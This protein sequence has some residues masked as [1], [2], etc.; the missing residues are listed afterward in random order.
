M[1]E[2]ALDA[3]V[4]FARACGAGREIVMISTEASQSNEYL[5]ISILVGCSAASQLRHNLQS[6]GGDQQGP[7]YELRGKHQVCVHQD[8]FRNQR[9]LLEVMAPW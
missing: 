9:Q 8:P 4:L 2:L 1:E 7:F 6:R 3:A 5:L